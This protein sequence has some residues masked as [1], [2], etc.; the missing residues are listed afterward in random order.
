MTLLPDAVLRPGKR[1]AS[2]EVV[3]VGGGVI[4][5]AAAWQLARRGHDVVVLEKAELCHPRVS[6][7]GAAR[8]Y[9]QGYTSPLHVQLAV[10]SLQRWRQLEHETGAALLTLTGGIDHG[11]QNATTAIAKTLAGQGIRHEWLDPAEASARWP[12]MQF[13][14]P[15]LH[16]PD[17]AGRL[18]ADQ[19]VAA[20]TAAAMGR[21][22]TVR[23]STPVEQIEILGPDL[24]EVHTPGGSIRTRRVV[25]A[26]GAWT[27]GL[28][29]DLVPLPPLQVT[30]EQPAVFPLVGGTPSVPTDLRWPTFIHHTGPDD[31]WPGGVYGVGVP[32]AGV[33]VGF[34]GAGSQWDPERTDPA[35]EPAQ[36]GRLQEYV[37]AFLPGLDVGAPT[38]FR[39]AFVSTP[40]AEFLVE[41]N[42]PLVV[43]AG[44]SG[45]GFKF[46]TALGRMVCDLAGDSDPELRHA[47][48][49][50]L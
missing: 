27:A 8:V 29:A 36:L 49:S 24:A 46:A 7:H 28:V 34:G 47:P 31:G 26:A 40:D 12:G 50:S 2:V 19:A 10:E 6:P 33:K 43:A 22:A 42:G 4:G 16:Q 48:A 13:D 38:P 21:G 25:L 5:A 30:E 9:R 37:E 15:V 11:D 1:S 18:R 20:L 3:V 32:C 41:R 17:S 35:P 39:C 14:G 23:Y 45:H 44:F